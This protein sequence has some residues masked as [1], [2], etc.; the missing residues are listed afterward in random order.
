MKKAILAV[1][2]LAS[3]AGCSSKTDPNES[4]FSDAIDAY[5]AKKG[6]LCLND[7]T[8]PSDKTEMDEKL[9]ASFSGGSTD[10]MAALVS[11]GLITSEKSEKPIL[12]FNGKPTGR[13]QRITHYEITEKGKSFFQESKSRFS[14]PKEGEIRGA[15]CYGKKALAEIIKWEGPMKMG[16]YQAAEIFY[17]YKVN[18]LAEWAKTSE[19]QSAFPHAKEWIDGAGVKQQK[20]GVHL[21]SIGWEA[22]GIDT[23]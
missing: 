23:E 18:D 8:W 21:T 11:A 14:T 3:I 16:D 19:F 22:N 7:E 1:T 4:N 20:H 5:L 10:R 6:S 17:H 12:G 9:A 2:F 13:T 15:F